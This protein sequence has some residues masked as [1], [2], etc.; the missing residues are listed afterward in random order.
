M[1][2]WLHDYWQFL[3]SLI[4]LPFA[5]LITKTLYRAIWPGKDN[6]ERNFDNEYPVRAKEVSFIDN[7]ESKETQK[8]DD[9][10]WLFI[11][12]PR[13]C[14]FGEDRVIDR[15]QFINGR[16]GVEATPLKYLITISGQRGIYEDWFR[17]EFSEK[18]FGDGIQVEFQH[19]LKVHDF[20]VAIVEPRSNKHWGFDE[21]RIREI[22]FV[23]KLGRHTI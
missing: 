3:F 9:T 18:Q 21:I 1:A 12:K 11:N 10:F 23:G 5:W 19:P 20:Y 13:R 17:R 15:I 22:M 6:W 2:H 4:L 14:F 8:V 16:H 7:W